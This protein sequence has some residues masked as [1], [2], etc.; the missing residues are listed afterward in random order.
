MENQ[1]DGPPRAGTCPGAGLKQISRPH[2]TQ[3]PLCGS[4]Q[5]SAGVRCENVSWNRA[6]AGI[7][8]L[9]ARGSAI[10]ATLLSPLVK[11][12]LF[13]MLLPGWGRR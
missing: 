10:Q 6:M 13:L 9:T 8:I 7:W 2:G 1:D 5:M 11:F 3:A 4:F 12:L